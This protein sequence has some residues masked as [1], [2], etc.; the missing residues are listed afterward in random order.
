MGTSKY[1]KIVGLIS[2]IALVIVLNIELG[3]KRILEIWLSSIP[4]I[5]HKVAA[6][7][8]SYGVLFLGWILREHLGRFIISKFRNSPD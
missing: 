6:K 3:E 2:V 5:D 4:D 1:E 7:N 8:V